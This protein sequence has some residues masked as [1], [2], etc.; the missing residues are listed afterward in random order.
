MIKL[1]GNTVGGS[2][3]FDVQRSQTLLGGGTGAV[4]QRCTCGEG[5]EEVVD[6][7]GV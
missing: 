2:N 3:I 6:E 1:S 4:G 5:A 7:V